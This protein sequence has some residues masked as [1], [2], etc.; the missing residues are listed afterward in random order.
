MAESVQWE[1]HVSFLSYADTAAC[2]NFPPVKGL[3]VE[4]RL[5]HAL[6]FWDA[7]GHLT[8]GQRLLPGSVPRA[9]LGLF[10]VR[11]LGRQEHAPIKQGCSGV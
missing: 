1:P 10:A 9:L 6:S 3:F 4:A 8:P 7:Q 2:N 11:E 5:N